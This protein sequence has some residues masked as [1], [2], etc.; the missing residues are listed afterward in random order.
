MSSPRHLWSGDWE[1][2]SSAAREELARRRAQND[3]SS[4]TQPE[5]SP[6]LARHAAAERGSS[7]RRA[8]RTRL[9]RLAARERVAARAPLGWQLRIALLIALGILVLAGAAYGVTKIFA[10]SG[11]QNSAGAN[12]VH[13]WLGIDVVGSPLGILIASVA[14]GSPAQV[15]GNRAGRSDQPDRRSARRDGRRRLRG[16]QG[17][18]PRR[19]DKYPAQPRTLDLH[20]AGHAGRATASLPMS[21]ASPLVLLA[22]LAIP[23]LVRWYYGLAA[24]RAV[25]ASAFVAPPLHTLG[26][27]RSGP[28]WRRHVPMLAFVLALA[29]LI[30]AAA[31]RSAASRCRS[32]RRDHAR[33]RR[34][35]LDGGDRRRARRGS[36][37][38]SARPSSSR[39]RPEHGP[40]RA[41]ASSHERR[42]CSSRR[43]PTTRWSVGAHA[44]ARLA[45]ARRSA[46]RSRPRSAMLTSLPRPSTA[47]VRRARSCCSPTAPRTSASTR[48]PRLA[49]ARAEHIPIYTVAL[50]T[51]RGTITDQARHPDRRHGPGAAQPP[52]ACGRSRGCPA[53]RRSRLPT[54]PG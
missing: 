7:W 26:R 16:P 22:L 15:G 11:T 46:T 9:G 17:P 50:G 27:A 13:S 10:G 14:P 12:T 45:A 25:A 4:E 49:Q 29:V 54:P 19:Y 34:Q 30:A 36:E 43:P 21:F 44:A 32:P 37:P 31:G 39:Q 28:R 41:D 53:A 51:S 24:A 23:L 5:A 48:S 33:Q 47:S 8:L 20:D 52:A 40:G 2:D 6:P 38:R 42:P 18:P 35:Q 3:E 1:L